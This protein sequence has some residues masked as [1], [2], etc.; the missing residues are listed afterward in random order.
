[1]PSARRHRCSL[2]RF[3][4][5]GVD[6]RHEG[7]SAIWR[8]S[9]KQES[10]F[11]FTRRGEPHGDRLS[12]NQYRRLVK[13]WVR[14]IGL[15]PDDYSTH[16]LRRTL[17]SFV[18]HETKNIEAVRNLLGQSSVTATSRYLNVAGSDSLN[19]ARPFRI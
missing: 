5:S 16:S 1:M 18:Y 17:P 3:G 14:A 6:L 19:L 11:L 13:G 12:T 7:K 8:C 9:P 10:D 15:N 2:I 4:E